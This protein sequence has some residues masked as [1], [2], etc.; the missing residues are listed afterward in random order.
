MRSRFVR[1]LLAAAPILGAESPKALPAFFIPNQGQM[2]PNVRFAIQTPEVNAGFTSGGIVFKKRDSELRLDFRGANV[3]AALSGKGELAGRASFLLGDD[4][5]QWKRDVPLF[6]RIHYSDLYPGISAEYSMDGSR[7]KSEYVVEP[8]ADPRRIAL[9]YS[10]ATSIVASIR[11]DR[12]LSIRAG[13]L[14]MIE[15]APLAYQFDP[16]GDRRIVESRYVLIDS[17][18]VGFEL[19]A[20]NPALTLIVDP[21]ITYATYIGGSGSSAVTSLAVDSSGNL[22]VAGWTD[23]IDFPIAGAVQ[24]ANHGGVD[25]F[26]AKLNASGSGLVYATYV[27]GRNDDR[28]AG[29]AVDSSGN[30]VVA[31]STTSS[32]FPV[33]S[34]VRN[35]LAGGRDAFVFKLNSIGNGFIYST[36]LGGS[37]TDQANAIALDPS[38][39]SYVAGDTTSLDFPVQSARQIG[40]AGRTDVFLTKLTPA[41]LILFSTYLGGSADDHAGAIAVGNNGA[42]YV[43]GGTFSADFPTAGAFQSANAGAQDAFV[44]EIAGTGSPLFFSSYL[45]GA[46]GA[47]G[48]PEE[49]TGIAVDSSGNIYVAGVTNSANFPTTSSSFQ[50]TF[51]GSQD[52]FVTKINSSGT[53][54]YSTYLGT[55]G[56]E[57]ASALAID[58]S[59]NAYVAGYTSATSFPQTT[60]VQTTFGGLYDAFISKLNPGGNGLSF[61]TFFGGSGA[62]QANA[63]AIDS[64]GNIYAGGQTSSFDLPTHS[65]IQAHNISGSTGWVARLG[66]TAPP[67]QVPSVNS[68][69]PASGSGNTVTYTATYSHPAGAAALTSASLLVS[70]SASTDIACYVTY[71]ASNAKFSLY[72]DFAAT[73]ST[74]VPA[75]G[76]AQNSQCI[77]NGAGSSVSLSGTTL[78][79]T[80]AITFQQAFV[81]NKTV[82]LAATDANTNTGFVQKGSW[83]VTLPAPQ[84]SVA[85]VNPS[86]GQGTSQTFTFAFSDTLNPQNIVATEFQFSASG[87]AV[88][89]CDV[90]YNPAAGTITLLGDNGTS[91][92]SKPFGSSQLIANSQCQ[93]GAASVT[94][95][96]LQLLETVSINFF[97][98]FN[99]AK[100]IYASATE[101]ASGTGFVLVGNYTVASP[102]FPT[103]N[104]VV[105]AS[106]SGPAQRFTLTVSDAGGA[107]FINGVAF[108]I[109]SNNTTNACNVVYDRTANTITLSYDNPANG[110]AKITLGSTQL[111]SNS[112]CTINGANTTVFTGPTQ[113][114]FTIDVA[115]NSSFFGP[116]FIYGYAGESGANTG[117]VLVG[118]WN[119]TGGTPSSGTVSPASGTGNFPTFTFTVSDSVSQLNISGMS[120]LFTTGAPTNTSNAC[121]LVYNR[122][123]STIG[124][125]ANDG[126]TLNTKPIGSSATL[127]NSQCAV[128]YTVATFSGTTVTFQIQIAFMTPSFDGTKTVYLQ[129][130]EPGSN[131]GFVARGTWTVQ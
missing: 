62:D 50:T 11:G 46:G 112:Q 17:H 28:A 36:Y 115:F 37:G 110:A 21:V 64:S 89:A 75:G 78:T 127:Q 121:S 54:A 91:Q 94:F 9:S 22:Y 77:V 14:E 41:G 27:G 30:A 5:K 82:Y 72:N 40:N 104:S 1:L 79:M 84:P 123:N 101:A 26:V 48:T 88:G 65:P 19:E 93:V 3:E 122:A 20:Y 69:S 45:G 12:S 109:T 47:P 113:L 76:P 7:I 10:G 44:T 120:M 49:A 25:A 4:P 74:T 35:L 97:G 23:S 103:V 90:L 106:G 68:L 116:K 60:P 125:Y 58:S 61:S 92:T 99:G 51:G 85:G 18:T 80:L 16:S 6:S 100:N 2:S 24:A 118:S 33:M 63:L 31:G 43:A 39:N 130:N 57:W 67:P 96:G 95:V 126:V 55:Y 38:G 131:S 83:S 124:L 15:Q 42:L 53:I 70:N 119:V 108:L 111:I 59:G 102:G 73:G 29:I 56:F 81:G 13:G 66:V 129:A 117:N 52:A 32:N 71:S 8:G 114:V 128:G 34:A 105:P 87:S 107:S 98:S 86:T